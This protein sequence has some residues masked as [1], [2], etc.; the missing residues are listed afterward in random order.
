[1]SQLTE[2]KVG[3]WIQCLSKADLTEILNELELKADGTSLARAARLQNLLLGIYED[4]DFIQSNR[5]DASEDWIKR[6]ELRSA[7]ISRVT[8]EKSGS[9]IFDQNIDHSEPHP[10]TLLEKDVIVSQNIVKMANSWMLP[11]N[12]EVDGS[13]GSGLVENTGEPTGPITQVNNDHRTDNAVHR[14][15]SPTRFTSTPGDG[16]GN[17]ENE[18]VTTVTRGAEG[19]HVQ[20]HESVVEYMRHVD[21]TME[22]LK[23]FMVDVTRANKRQQDAIDELN[24]WRRAVA[25]NPANGRATST[26]VGNVSETYAETDISQVDQVPVRNNGHVNFQD[27]FTYKR[28]NSSSPI[29]SATAERIAQLQDQMSKIQQEISQ[30]QEE[31]TRLRENNNPTR[32]GGN[33]DRRDVGHIVRRW[34]VKF[35]GDRGQSI[36]HFLMRVEECRL[37]AGLSEVD[38]LNS[39]SELLTGVAATWYR[40]NRDDWRNWADFA[41]DARA[42]YGNSNF[43]QALQAEALARTQGESEPVRDYITNLQSYL[44]RIQPQP[45]IEQQIELMLRN[46]LPALQKIIRRDDIRDIRTLKQRAAEAEQLNEVSKYFKPPPPVEKS[47]LQ[48]LAYKPKPQKDEQKTQVS[49][50]NTRSEPFEER[51]LKLFERLDK[52]FSEF[53]E[54]DKQFRKLLNSPQGQHKEPKPKSDT[55]GGEKQKP[56]KPPSS[57]T[58]ESSKGQ[59]KSGK[60]ANKPTI[61]YNCKQPGHIRPNCPKKAENS[62]EVGE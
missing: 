32:Q 20:T 4:N 2:E 34:N 49:A 27:T 46:M 25:Q 50:T 29:K 40:N 37:L 21:A 60:S 3:Q 1:M 57:G 44:R 17:K 41:R 43:Q 15:K 28:Y 42:W 30:L 19:G 33:Q 59:S 16:V 24:Q 39:L 55:Q 12:T 38:V 13:V 22:E 52:K 6:E 54:R 36:E 5:A 53:E 61:C 58:P 14:N 48:E 7:F 23:S 51:M 47:V 35:T 9:T 11:R 62:E 31:P 56:G 26:R 18:D 45:T 10:L 8:L